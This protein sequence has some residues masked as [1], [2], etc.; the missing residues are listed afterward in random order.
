MRVID[1]FR[2]V[3]SLAY[4]PCCRFLY[5]A[6]WQHVSRWDVHSGA[7]TFL[8]DA[9]GTGY[10]QSVAVSP[11]GGKVGW[12]EVA[13]KLL[14]VAV[15]LDQDQ[16]LPVPLPHQPA[17]GAIAGLAML[18]DESPVVHAGPLVADP[19]G[20]T[21]AFVQ[22]RELRL[23]TVPDPLPRATGT[24]S[25]RLDS[26]SGTTVRRVSGL[27]GLRFGFASDSLLWWHENAG[28]MIEDLA[29]RAVT[30]VERPERLPHAVTPNGR[31]GIAATG[32]EVL[33]IDLPSGLTR[34]RFNW[35]VGTVEAVAVAPDGLT[36]AVAGWAGGI[37]IFDLDG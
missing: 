5:S 2:T 21:V 7:E 33:L 23:A 30:R 10:H 9:P 27:P 13:A 34:E 28:L 31:T 14:H 26:V 3:M 24:Q 4:S 19:T 8:Y 25:R 22:A 16:L 20:R 11:H 18:H 36:A 32:R 6:G 12:V 35:D 17:L 1:T 37:A 29:S 15:E